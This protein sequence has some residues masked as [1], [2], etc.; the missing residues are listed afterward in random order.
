MIKSSKLKKTAIAL[1]AIASAAC[2][3]S[4]TVAH[5]F[6]D[7]SAQS[8]LASNTIDKLD[9]SIDSCIESSFDSSVVYRLPET[10][11]SDQEI[12]VIVTMD[13]DS[14]VD[15]YEKS[16]YNGSLQSYLDTYSAERTA[17]K[18]ER[19]KKKLIETLD[20]S[21]VNY[22]LGSEYDAVLSGFEITL[23]AADFDRVD[24][25]LGDSAKL[26]VSEVYYEAETQIVNNE[27]DVY[28]TGIFNS[29]E[30]D[31]HGDG[32]I[33][34]VLDTGCDY[35][36]TAFSTANFTTANEAF[37][38]NVVNS[39]I[40]GTNA[41]ATTSG[42]TG[43]D[44][45]VSRKIPFAYDYADKDSDV[46]P[47][48]SSHGT[49]VAGII[50]GNDDTITGVAPNAQL[51]IMKVFSDTQDGAKTSWI[52]AAVD[53][54]VKLGVDVINMSLGTSCG[55]SREIDKQNINEIYDKVKSTG[56]SLIAAASN[57]Y[58][59]TFGSDKN[60]S[61]GLTS[62]PDSGTVGSPSTYAA[63]LSVA[64][65][66]G[67][68]TP[69]LTHD[70]RIIYFKEAST[71]SAKNKD[72]VDDVLKTVG[73]VDS[74]DFTYVTIPGIGRSADYLE[75]KEFYHDKIVL[76]RRGTTTFEDKVRI[77][78]VEKG[79]AGIII[80]NNVSGDISM[81]VG[82]DI[83][84]VCSIS[85]DEGEILAKAGTGILHVSR[86]QVAGPFMSDFSSW[87]PTSDLKI[88]PEITAHGGEILSCVPG[89]NY[90]RLSGTSMAAPNQ[91][92][93]TALIRQYVKDNRDVFGDLSPIEVTARV[94][95]L[96]MSTADIIRNKN[97]LA[98]SVRKQGAGLM[99]MLAATETASYI[100]TYD[101]SGK[102]MDKSKIELG[103][104]KNK[105]GVYEATFGITNVSTSAVTYA[106]DAL[107]MTEGVSETYTSHGD[108]TVTQDGRMLDGR[109]VEI[110]AVNGAGTQNGMSVSVNARSTANVTVKITLSDADKAYLDKSF[111]H[112]MYVEGFITLKASAGTKIDMN[113]PM[114]AF[115]GDWTEAP[116]FDE[117]YYDTN[118]DEINAGLD[119]E[120]K[121]MPD[122]Y[123]TRVLGG[124]YSDYIST[125]G[126]YYFIQ[127]P[128]ASKIAASKDHIALSNQQDGT[129][130]CVNR[131]RSIT[132]GLLRNCRT[133]DIR[134]T[135]DATGNEIFS[136]TK[137]N[138]RKSFSSGNNI[139]GSSI[140]V[141]FSVLEHNL[142]NNTKYTVTA[143]AYIDYGENYSQKNVRNT[144]TF[145]L[146]I[147]FEAPIVTD[148]AYRTEY[149]RTTKKTKLFAD[150]SVYDNH[151]AMG[152]QVG[153]I[154]ESKDP[155]YR[156]SLSSFGK[157]VTPVYSNFNSTS[158]VT[159]EL[160]DYVAKI[161]NSR[162]IEY[163]SDGTAKLV[164]NNN[165]FIVICYD[166]A[167]NSA[168]Y[169]LR[170]PDE[171][172]AMYFANG[173]EK[174]DEIR[175]SPNEALNISSLL[176]IYPDETWIDVLD[177]TTSDKDIA[178]IIN[179]TIIAKSSG[180]AVITAI[181]YDK[182]GNRIEAT[183]NVKVLAEGEEGYVGGYSITEVNKFQ[184]N[185]YTTLKAYYAISSEDRKIGITDGTYD[186][187]SSYALEMYPSESVSVKYKSLENKDESDLNY[188]LDSYYPEKTS[189]EFQVGNSKIATVTP[190]GV[191]T[192]Q[193]EGTTI[194]IVS[195]R[196]NGKATL[197]SQRITI[198][199]KDP[200]TTQAIYLMSYKGLGGTVTVP[201][202][203]G[204]T[205]IYSYAFSNYEYVDKDP[206]AGDI[207][208]EEDPYLIKQMYI[209]ED[210]IKKIILPEGVEEI[211]AYAFAK[212]TALEEVVL[213]STLKKI[214]GGAFYGCE[215]LKKINLEHVQFINK[216]AFYGCALENVNLASVVAVGNYT[217]AH[218]KLVSLTLPDT[219]QSLG[220]G[221]FR[222]NG[223]LASL[224][225][226]ASKIKIAP[227]VFADCTDL[228]TVKINA[229]V[230]PTFAFYKC[231]DLT[232]V[233][234][235]N[236]VA[237]IGEY[238]F[239]GTSVAK[240]TLARGN[241]A[242]TLKNG[243]A[244]V[245]SG[246][247]LILR[248]PAAVS[249]SGYITVEAEE[250]VAGAF[251][252]N[253][254][255]TKVYAPNAKVVGA[256]A[257]ADCSLLAEVDMP[258]LTEIG[259]YAF[260]GTKLGST[261]DLSGVKVIGAFAFAGSDITSVTIAPD[262]VVCEYAF[263][264]CSEL[265][266]V[267]IGDG[268]K[269]GDYAFC[270][271]INWFTYDNVDEDDDKL[272]QNIMNLMYSAYTYEIKD[273]SGEVKDTVTFYR[274]NINSRVT[275]NSLRVSVS[276]LQS[277]SLGDGVTLGD[278]SF[279]GNIKL[280]SINF[281]DGTNIGNYAFYNASELKEVDLSKVKTIGDFAFSGSVTYDYMVAGYDYDGSVVFQRAYNFR[282]ED[283]VLVADSY[284]TT[285]FAPKFGQADLS[286]A[287][288]IGEG[289]FAYNTALTSVTLG[290]VNSVSAY[291]FARCSSLADVNLPDSVKTIGGYA[292]YGAAVTD[293]DLS[294]VD[295]IGDAAFAYCDLEEVS[296]KEGATVGGSTFESNERL[297]T[298]TNLD[299]AVSIGAYA[300]FGSAL[301]EV[302]LTQAET[303]GDYAFAESK[304]TRVTFGGKLTEL[305]ENPF[306][307]CEI[308]TYA[309]KEEVKFDGNAIEQ[310]EVATYDVSDS[311]KV[312]DGVLYKKVKNGLTLVS[313]PVASG[314]AFYKVV[315]GTVRISARAF[316]GSALESVTLASTLKA[317]GDKA[318][319][320]CEA[321]NSVAFL[322]Y[323]APTL[324]EEYNETYANLTN[325]PFS[326]YFSTYE[327][328]GISKYYM[329]N[330]SGSPNNFYFGANFV[331]YIG[332][333]SNNL[334]MVRPANGL[335]YDT[336]ILS[337][338]FKTSVNGGNAASAKALEVIA[339]IAALPDE[340]TLDNANAVAAARNAYDN[341]SDDQKQLISNV[342]KLEKAE[343]TL[344]ALTPAEDKKPTQAKGND[345]L[346]LVIVGFVLA[347]AALIALAAY[348]TVTQ[349]KKKMGASVS[350]DTASEDE[351]NS[352]NGEDAAE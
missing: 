330:V 42:L 310:V 63:S 163:T 277:V 108:T 24:A 289:A 334:V 335:N 304:I 192:A 187:G 14:Y 160:T 243:G 39:K 275:I 296:L 293:V 65:V 272:K 91:A 58:N 247:K 270:N 212:L 83:G 161:K 208:D 136:C 3:T 276:N 1:L 213:P 311:V 102:A 303:V 232:V 339:N 344:A 301:T 235:G 323:E 265:K 342:T 92:G 318:F 40:A 237:Q 82:K 31:Y 144:F 203:R 178:D 239:A 109:K 185:S 17:V 43:S 179:N 89:Q 253:I 200:Y 141:D 183:L 135:E 199:V 222:Y 346:V 162:G 287:T 122:A 22:T 319:Y 217:F 260:A 7:K 119:D 333:I 20:K 68:K 71:S 308:E 252:G 249:A 219:A 67:V 266:S 184:L 159:V 148:V 170:L 150:L 236:D 262:T 12:S 69:Y 88:K 210:T 280:K 132:A 173:G 131:I 278:Y 309:K 248:A 172:S 302:N 104:D 34:A 295:R 76:V 337:Q 259:E 80:Y 98:Y 47:I 284:V 8:V 221:A 13:T 314:N 10:V 114:L 125:L 128:S 29:S 154:T 206:A 307:N 77:A 53:D 201:D 352:E 313:Y 137:S 327:G 62:N 244:D 81:S 124:L 180:T 44:V 317:I 21:G 158:V 133:V 343:K 134:I 194:V 202:D 155:Q 5:A 347:G 27:V 46:A 74:Y 2:I 165:S 105:S 93:A 9:L 61:L 115:Y 64:S 340:I 197:Y 325:L 231:S 142:K 33:V 230:I 283:G 227:Y 6:T 209:G 79:A 224:T 166:Y 51:A 233:E 26:I 345:N 338:Y 56:I 297:A 298:V 204:I 168:T 130:S 129:N 326:G 25:L 120:D 189:V 331:D 196:F 190:D 341:L 151:Y 286:A 315:E 86:S 263:F 147:D 258:K 229:V 111:K 182:D 320:G 110:T 138:L 72:F 16:G 269:I 305:G 117:E 223:E 35:T 186:F 97:G 241:T 96:M 264:Y 218:N 195:V 198:T 348:I 140:E 156:F 95:Q 23:K 215:K 181:G 336:F 73:G 149:D 256:Y 41:A 175:L 255:V 152:M 52:L 60:G 59:A 238:A 300:F 193:A 282:Y 351:T 191:I 167:M 143:T 268:A 291:A 214:G 220:E 30:C 15:A 126:T 90:D 139:Y 116:I 322:S 112:G 261:P 37:T 279:A 211:Q 101:D 4:S 113:V 123:A 240:F 250:I 75:A 188:V 267:V 176:N 246:D 294:K 50:A 157:Y 257:F 316:S 274:F 103:D 11:A 321:L 349:L 271:P 228:R 36:H 207:I 146:F 100:T 28:E 281:G 205:T 299:K 350:A 273:E 57:D 78:L 118:K 216:E 251:A 164:E 254:E 169:E 45:Y 177:F 306:Y 288:S 174:V 226:R 87:G 127:D 49:H 145:P 18:I 285:V 66:D 19:E 85:Q 48:S 106:I 329:W 242:L 94:N 245:Y 54:C 292:F 70:G 55:F 84:A 332:H 328:L 225:F 107:V 290:Q 121:L 99:N 38:L 234:F 32:V 153:Q 171:V 312:I 324:E